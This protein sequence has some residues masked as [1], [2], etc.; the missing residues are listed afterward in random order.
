MFNMGVTLLCNLILLIPNGP[1]M[2][3][4]LPI[5]IKYSEFFNAEFI[6]IK[7]K[8]KSYKEICIV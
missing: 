4:N 1:P 3:G 6:S 7:T 8:T 2:F 5:A